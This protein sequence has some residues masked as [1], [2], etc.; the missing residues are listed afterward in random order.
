MKMTFNR[1]QQGEK[2][3]RKLARLPGGRTNIN[4]TDNRRAPVISRSTVGGNPIII[5]NITQTATATIQQHKGT[6]RVVH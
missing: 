6:H 5:T 1:K 3:F 2:N 4:K